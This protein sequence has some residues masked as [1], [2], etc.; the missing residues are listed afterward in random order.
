MPSLVFFI[1]T[2]K[3]INDA[4]INY[5]LIIPNY[6]HSMKGITN[7]ISFPSQLDLAVETF[8]FNFFLSSY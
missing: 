5:K 3:V 8:L 2:A 6:L 4:L 7:S 1:I